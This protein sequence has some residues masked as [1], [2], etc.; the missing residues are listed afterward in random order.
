MS[1]DKVFLDTNIIIYAY[2]ISAGEKREIAR[3]II[4]DLW[5][6]GLGLLSTQVLQEFFVS[7]T[8]K[9]LKPLDVKIAEEIVSD[10]LK[11]D[12]I[13]NDGQSILEAIDIH[14]RYKYSF[15]DSMI[16]QAALKGNASLL[17]SEDLSDGQIINGVRIKNPFI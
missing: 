6:S 4:T 12:V 8:K 15:W 5:G 17:L 16:I 1:G 9:I 3:K 14:S 13:V 7:I 11:W 2:D 10:L